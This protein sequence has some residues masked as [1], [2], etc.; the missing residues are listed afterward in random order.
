[1]VEGPLSPL[2]GRPL[3]PRHIYRIAYLEGD[4]VFWIGPSARWR[5]A[6]PDMEPTSGS[7]SYRRI[8]KTQ[9]RLD[10]QKLV[11]AN[12]N[13]RNGSTRLVFDTATVLDI[14]RPGRD[15]NHQLWTLRSHEQEY[16]TVYGDAQYSLSDGTLAS[17]PR[18][19][20]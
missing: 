1:M 8:I 10:G 6:F 4:W 14:K 12:V 17:P 15:Y 5:A 20:I 11:S 2:A 13:P 7:S 3:R 9:A 18:Q 19:S 16:L